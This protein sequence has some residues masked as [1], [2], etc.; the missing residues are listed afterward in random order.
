MYSGVTG[1]RTSPSAMSEDTGLIRIVA[2]RTWEIKIRRIEETSL[3]SV[4]TCS[5][6]ALM[7]LEYIEQGSTSLHLREREMRIVR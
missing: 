5:F 4:A 6:T 3:N 1:W 2:R 7:L